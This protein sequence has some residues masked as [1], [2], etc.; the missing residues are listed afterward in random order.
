MKMNNTVH[1]YIFLKHNA[2]HLLI[3]FAKLVLFSKMKEYFKSQACKGVCMF[4]FHCRHH[5]VPKH[6]RMKAF[7][8]FFFFTK[9]F[10]EHLGVEGG[11]RNTYC[12][13]V[14]VRIYPTVVD[15][16]LVMRR[17][18]MASLCLTKWL[19]MFNE[20]FLSYYCLT[21]RVLN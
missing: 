10:E 12:Q 8:V 14:L 18:I 13:Y 21:Q 4:V 16:C 3:P 9:G 5:A 2:R 11:C 20:E 15:R 19:T 1:S 17:P 6:Y 7:H